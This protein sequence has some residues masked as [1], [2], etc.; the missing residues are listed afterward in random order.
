MIKAN[1]FFILILLIVQNSFA[2]TVSSFVTSSWEESPGTLWD[3]CESTTGWTAS[4][5]TASVSANTAGTNVKQGLGSVNFVVTSF[6]TTA[7]FT[8]DLGAVDLS[9]ANNIIFWARFTGVDNI[10]SIKVQISSLSDFSKNFSYTMTNGSYV[11]EKLRVRWQRFLIGTSQFTNNGADS[12]TTA[13]YFR[14]TFTLANSTGITMSLDGLGYGYSLNKA[15]VIITFDDGYHNL[16]TRAYPVMVS[17]GQKAVYYINPSFVNT[18][19][20]E[21]ERMTTSE[22]LEIF[23]SGNDVSN[24]SWSHINADTLSL[25]AHLTEVSDAHDWLNA[26]GFGKTSKFFS[27]PHG[28]YNY[29]SV[30][31]L[32]NTFTQNVQPLSFLSRST[33]IFPVVQPAAIMNEQDTYANNSSLLPI[34]YVLSTTTTT[35]VQNVIDAAISAKGMVI[36]LFHRIIADD[37]AQDTLYKYKISD[38]TTI[39]NYIKT[40]VDANTLDVV[41]MSD[42]YKSFVHSNL[43]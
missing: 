4:G 23:N 35:D 25:S 30:A 21:D 11:Y 34:Y 6:N 1:I 16:Y 22:L 27:W 9:A 41:T 19:S 14:I 8:K 24:H 33:H 40:K 17:N 13:R 12:W 2:D 15:K 37:E 38:F 32:P 42:Y 7:T 20:G 10:T 18:G 26:N 39:S 3:G 5:S 28:A 43:F 36:L 31:S 29:N